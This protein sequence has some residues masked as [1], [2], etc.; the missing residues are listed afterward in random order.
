M[1]N[2]I[3]NKKDFV[4][5]FLAAG[6]SSRFGNKI[7][8]LAK[9][10]PNGESLIEAS[11]GQA[12]SAG[13]N[14]I[15]LIVGDLTEAPI[16]KKLGYIYKGIP[17][18]YVKQNFSTEE[19]DRPWG[20]A[21]ALCSINNIVNNPFVVCNGDD[22]YGEK[23]FKIL[24]NHIHTLGTPAIIGYKLSESL[25]DNGTVNRGIFEVRA[26]KVVKI[27]ETF[28]IS[29]EDLITKKIDPESLCS[30][31]ISVLNP[32]IIKLLN[33]KLLQFK[34]KHVGD[35]KTECI[36]SVELS[37]L[38]EEGKIEMILLSTTDK[39]MG[40][41]NPGDEIIIRRSLCL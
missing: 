8:Q 36:L 18:V 14:K 33:K 20:T 22:I 13:F 11:V 10:G 17:I 31:C 29:K 28:N 3:K 7:K 37:N 4:A 1:L 38:I 12:I 19:R 5:V 16:K 21:D 39:W 2:K 32:K 35:R 27:T 6:V 40:I 23:T 24:L 15:I 30:Q 9:V 41:T 26:G 25:S 34:R